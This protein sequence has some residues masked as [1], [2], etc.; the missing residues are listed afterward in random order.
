MLNTKQFDKDELLTLVQSENFAG[1]V[2]SIDYEKALIITN[3][4]WKNDVKGIPHNSFLLAA[5]FDPNNYGDA[6]EIDKEVVLLRVIDTCRLPQD[7]DMIKTKIDNYQ[8]KTSVDTAD[9]EFDTITRNKLQFSGLEC[10]VLGTF[11]MKN[12]QL[13]LGSDIESFSASL[14][15]RVYAPK[16]GAL[17]KIV[18]F[19]DPIRKNKSIRIECSKWLQ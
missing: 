11:Y 16:K 5:S 3:D 19:V 15:T 14:Q 4:K 7:D 6:D 8:N 12:N 10:R 17:D 2:Y 13:N 9:D 1:W 18:N